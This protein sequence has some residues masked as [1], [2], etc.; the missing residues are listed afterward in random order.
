MMLEGFKEEF[1]LIK[2]C[3][4]ERSGVRCLVFT[5]HL[6]T[7]ILTF[8]RRDGDCLESFIEWMKSFE[9]HVKYQPYKCFERR[10]VVNGDGLGRIQ[11][12]VLPD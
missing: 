12:S 11:G 10:I 6:I 4:N 8:R 3:E 7:P 9:Q 5:H 1:S 2:L